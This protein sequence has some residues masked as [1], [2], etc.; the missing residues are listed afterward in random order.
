MEESFSNKKANA[1]TKEESKALADKEPEI[2]EK[3]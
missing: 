3:I 1:K 2:T